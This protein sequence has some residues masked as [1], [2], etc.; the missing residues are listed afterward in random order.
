MSLKRKGTE[1]LLFSFSMNLATKKEFLYY[2]ELISSK[3]VM[4]QRLKL[5][6]AFF[7][8]N[9]TL[10][11]R[12]KVQKLCDDEVILDYFDKKYLQ[13]NTNEEML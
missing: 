3:F 1:E 2:Y 8:N 6:D 10:K 7:R 9:Y 13:T 5:I 12:D 4:F 11:L